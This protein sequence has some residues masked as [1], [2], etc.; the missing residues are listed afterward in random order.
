LKYSFKRATPKAQLTYKPWEVDEKDPIH[1]KYGPFLW[2]TWNRDN[3]TQ[4]VAAQQFVGRFDPAKPIVWYF[5]PGFPEYYKPIFV[6]TNGN[7]GIMQATNDVLKAS[8]AAARIQFLNYNDDKTYGDAAGPSRQYGDIRYNFFRWVSDQD[9]Q[10]S[11]AGVTMPGFDPR[12]GE[13]V[14]ECIEFNDFAVKDYYVQRI[15]AFLTAVGAS[16]GLQTGVP[17]QSGACTTGATAQIV[18]QSVVDN[19]NAQST[20]F[21]KMQQYL[22]LH[23]SDPLNDHLGP[24]D[25]VAVQDADFYR[26]YF[27]LAPYELFA[28]PDMNQF[29][30][31]EG[32][33]GVYGPA[34]V[35]KTLQGETQFQQL[36]AQISNGTAPA[37]DGSASTSWISASVDFANQMRSATQAHQKLQ[38]MKLVIYPNVHMDVPGAFSLETVMEQDAQQCVNGK[39][40][41]QDE[42]VQHIIDTYWQQ[43]FW[44]EFGHG[45]GLEHNFMGNIDQ[46]NFVTQRDAS[47]KVLTDNNGNPLYNMYSNSVMEYSSEPARLAWTQGW[48]TYDKG[49]IAWIYANNGKQPD[50]P[51]KDAAAAAAKSLSGE[52]AGAAAGQE[53]PY[54]DPLGFCA[55]NDPDCTAGA[56][57]AFLRCDE[58]HLTY[59]PLC[60]TGDL[61]VTPSQIMAN[62]IDDYEWQYQWRNFRDYRKVWDESGY[63]NGVAYYLLD[64]QRFLSQWIFDWSPGEIATLL[65][66]VGITPPANAP[67]AVDYYAQLTHKF[68]IEM[69]KANDM[70]ASFDE[71]VIQQSAGERPYATVYDK[72]YGDVTQQGIILDK[73]FAMQEFVGL[74]ISDNYDQ[75]QAGAYLSSWGEF[76]FDES[77]QAI[78]ETAI[79]SM[80]GSQYASYPYFIPTAVALFA[81]DTHNPAWLGGGGRTEAKDWIGGWTFPNQDFMNAYFRKIAA[82]NGLCQSSVNCSY[83]VTDP[84][85]VPKDP[86]DAHFVGP[87][88]LQYIY[89]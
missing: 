43:V 11:F 48:G 66:R 72:Y 44:H 1:R 74:W 83:D 28:D 63:A 36:S 56:E 52:V 10:G 41:T 15:D 82:N 54:K 46:P 81:Q 12:T 9:S 35:W 33:A 22:N 4:L 51:A 37:P 21:T 25:M 47:G 68:L 55:A 31:R 86:S 79:S 13:I 69:T 62:L 80:I 84:V 78:A 45:M 30:T 20:L 49:A 38:N 87:D 32:G 5:A 77:Y 26:A 29:V 89:M 39:W 65:Y 60:R 6:G 53:Y 24:Q 14:N 67:S 57:R 70:V 59:S 76:D 7:V 34:S 61:G 71:A 3:Q 85:M 2:T 88:G 58:T 42:W 73:Y 16:S 18:T 40:E 19:H 27:A 8:G 23:S 75:N 50:D 64:M 17:W